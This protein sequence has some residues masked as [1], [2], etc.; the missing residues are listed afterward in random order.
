[1]PGAKLVL[2]GG[3]AEEQV[4]AAKKKTAELDISDR[5][6]F[7]GVLSSEAVYEQFKNASIYISGSLEEGFPNV[8][9]EAMHY[10]LPIVA[11]DVGGSGELVRH[12]ETGFLVDPHDEEA[13]GKRVAE[14]ARDRALRNVF[15]EAAYERSKQFNLEV[16]VDTFI[17][18]YRSLLSK[19]IR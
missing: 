19:T 10:G 8:F 14:L 11:T 5:V 16:L 18:M 2:I 15:A 17:E 7:T 6:L 1:M 4:E 12:G 3:G 9:I 13:L